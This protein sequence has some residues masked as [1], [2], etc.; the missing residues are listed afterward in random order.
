MIVILFGFQVTE[1]SSCTGNLTHLCSQVIVSGEMSKEDSVQFI[2]KA[3]EGLQVYIDNAD[4]EKHISVCH[5][6]VVV[7]W[8]KACHVHS[9]SNIQLWKISQAC[10]HDLCSQVIISGEM[11]KDDS[12]QYIRRAV[13]GLQVYIDN[14]DCEKHISI[15]TTW[16]LFSERR[17]AVYIHCQTFSCRKLVK[18]VDMAQFV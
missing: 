9:L 18:H 7:F 10:W 1:P 16:L 3:V 4:G 15:V 12:V 5:N 14:A 2:K 17:L 13:E 8:M 6:L 11:S